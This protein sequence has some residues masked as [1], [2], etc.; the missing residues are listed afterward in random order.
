VNDGHQTVQPLHRSLKEQRTLLNSLVGLYARQS[1]M[2]HGKVHSELRR[3]C[4]GPAVGQATS[5]QIQQR[6]NE[7][8]RRL[9]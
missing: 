3:I 1:H 6:I 8:R 4:G 7:L 2:P 9:H 5:H